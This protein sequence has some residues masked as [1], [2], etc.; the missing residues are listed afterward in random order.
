AVAKP[1]IGSSTGSNLTLGTRSGGRLGVDSGP[2]PKQLV[3]SAAVRSSALPCGWR[4]GRDTRGAARRQYGIGVRVLPEPRRRDLVRMGRGLL[5]A[6][7]PAGCVGAAPGWMG[8]LSE[9][10]VLSATPP[11]QAQAQHTGT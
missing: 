10:A 7:W 2:S 9:V 11:E 6:A 1:N 8:L 5:R 3:K 4:A